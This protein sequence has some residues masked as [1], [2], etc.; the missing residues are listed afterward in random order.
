MAEV[1]DQGTKTLLVDDSVSN[2]IILQI[3]LTSWSITF[4]HNS[5]MISN[6]L[7]YQIVLCRCRNTPLRT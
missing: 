7:A 3:V 6:F 2:T 5:L 1:L 4:P